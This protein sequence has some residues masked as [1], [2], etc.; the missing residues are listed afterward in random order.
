M[1]VFMKI[2]IRSVLVI[3][4][5]AFI[6]LTAAVVLFL[7]AQSTR[8]SVYSISEKYMATVLSS[9]KDSCQAF[10]SS[11][12]EGNRDIAIHYW[13]KSLQSAMSDG[14]TDFEY[15]KRI[16]E[17]D[18]G[19]QMVY[20]ADTIG[21]MTMAR[22]VPD[23]TISKRIVRNDGEYIYENFYHQNQ[24]FNISFPSTV[25]TADE[26]YDPRKRSW[27]K[28][29]IEKRGLV[30]TDIYAFATGGQIG[31]S[32]SMPVYTPDAAL[33][34]VACIDVSIEGLSHFLSRFNLTPN[35]RLFIL[36]NQS[37]IVAEPIKEGEPLDRLFK[38]DENGI[39]TKNLKKV[40]E[41]D[42]ILKASYE[43]FSNEKSGI[44]NFSIGR[45]KYFSLY[46]TLSTEAGL[47]VQLGLVLPDEDVMGLVY[48]NN[49]K[50][51]TIIAIFILIAIL[52]SFLIA[53]IIA[54]PMD[55]LSREMEK[56][57]NFNYDS[58]KTIPT[59]ISEI[60]GMVSS[61]D[62]MK[63]GLNNFQKYVPTK[64]VNQLIAGGEL[65]T[66]GGQKKELTIF[67]SDIKNF[68]NISESMDPEELVMQMND[69]FSAVSNT[70]IDNEGTLDKYIGDAV[71]AFWGAPADNP[72]HAECAC[73]SA[74]VCQELI[75][76]LSH[77][78][79]VEGKPVF[80]TRI[81]IHTGNAV[82][83]NMGYEKRINYTVIG[84]SVN[85]ASRLEGINKFYGTKIII[86]Q[87]TYKQV[88]DKFHTRM[89]D[90]ITVK[91]KS[92]PVHIYELLAENGKLNKSR[93]AYY[94]LY[95]EGLKCYFAQN[96]NKAIAYFK[97][98]L[99]AKEEKS[100]ALMLE[101]CEEF[102]KNPPP[103]DW[104]GVH[105]FLQK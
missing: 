11:V 90:R 7:Y 71:M 105:E 82:V 36:D 101:R 79:R 91:G 18:N 72:N 84:D 24:E 66:V 70:I 78:W 102:K 98:M 89:L 30:W 37:Q 3:F 65:A 92:H 61:F 38:A 25:K 54:R 77:K 52:I 62:S 75:F 10:F 45:K 35:S 29:A 73:R 17:S 20:F 47:K 15:F 22:R 69:Y 26:G 97:K 83:G 28:A 42:E 6:I 58:E 51:L 49:I 88:K 23:N 57:K 21:G 48:K 46:E 2:K 53:R 9:V 4:N 40:T 95:E 1:G 12:E 59:S 93:V 50:I 41:D 55:S 103:K 99:S 63:T 94:R 14:D 96:W 19:F 86:S 104:N 60:G 44:H 13:T 27:Y 87:D 8:S 5:A 64:L 85:L 32:C 56:I 68:T 39:P 67:F 33:V 34:G 16:A 76:N 74:L 31:Y 100:A 81:G 43:Q 80:T